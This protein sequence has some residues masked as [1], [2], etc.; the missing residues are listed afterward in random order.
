MHGPS[1]ACPIR[2]RARSASPTWWPMPWNPACFPRSR[3]SHGAPR[4]SSWSP[5]IRAPRGPTTPWPTDRSAVP[6]C[7]SVPRTGSPMRRASPSSLAA[8][9]RRASTRS[10]WRTSTP[11]PSTSEPLRSG[12]PSCASFVGATSRPLAW[13]ARSRGAR[14]PRWAGFRSSARPTRALPGRVPAG[15]P[16]RRYGA[17]RTRRPRRLDRVPRG[18]DRPGGRV[19]GAKHAWACRSVGFAGSTC[20][21]CRPRRCARPWSTRSP[22]PTTPRPVHRSARRCSTNASRSRTRV[23]CSQV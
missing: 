17:R 5:S 4:T 18:G 7:G 20:W 2:W 12:S 19:R 11:K 6:T 1:P 14:S 16:L 13:C 3:W 15:G 21:P 22:T 9:V 23:S 8:W 10:R